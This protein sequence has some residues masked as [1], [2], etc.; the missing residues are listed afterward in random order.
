MTSLHTACANSNHKIVNE[1]LKYKSKV[2]VVTKNGHTP[3]H[4]A[5][6]SG[7][8]ECVMALIQC[9]A[10]VNTKTKSELDSP[11]HISCLRGH[12]KVSEYLLDCGAEVDSLNVLRRTPLHNAA[13]IGRVD[14]GK[15]LLSRGANALAL[16]AHAWEPRQIAEL[17]DHR[18]FQELI[19][20]EG[21]VCVSFYLIDQ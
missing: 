2:D 6:Y 12:G 14:I 5:A 17:N 7:S 8:L 16:D 18:S 10:N 15:L 11:L 19:I 9:S 21:C 1:L 13:M 20:R 3:L 4:L